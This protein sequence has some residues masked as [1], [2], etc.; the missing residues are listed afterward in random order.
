[1]LHPP[2][3]VRVSQAA[4]VIKLDGR[5]PASWAG[6]AQAQLQAWSGV[7]TI[8]WAVEIDEEAPAFDPLPEQ[9]AV[10]ELSKGAELD[11]DSRQEIE[12]IVSWF[13]APARPADGLRIQL[14][15]ETD[16]VGDP[17]SNQKLAE[18]RLLAVREA[19]LAAGL[20]AD[21]LLPGITKPEVVAGKDLSRRRVQV[22]AVMQQ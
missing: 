17:L 4:G 10:L 15:A 8:D 6:Q 19:L 18:A 13:K 12:K 20:E 7:M 16:G 14:T 22:D 11:D 5:A 9:P 21:R 2:A 3:G 1:M